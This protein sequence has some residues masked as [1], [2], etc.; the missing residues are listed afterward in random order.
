MIATG[1]QGVHNIDHKDSLYSITVSIGNP[2]QFF[3][4]SL[5]TG[6]ID[7]W[8]YSK[9]QKDEAKY[10][11]QNVSL[12]DPSKSYSFMKTK[13]LWNFVYDDFTYA[14][15]YIG[16]DSFQVGNIEI[17]GQKIEVITE[18]NTTSRGFDG[19]FGLG[20]PALPPHGNGATPQAKSPLENIFAQGHLKENVFAIQLNTHS[21]G[22]FTM[23]YYDKSQISKP[24]IKVPLN[25][26][27]ASKGMWMVD[28]KVVHI[29]GKPFQR[30][31]NTIMLLDSGCAHNYVSNDLVEAIYAQ[32]P[33]ARF[34]AQQGGWIYPYANKESKIVISFQIGSATFQVPHHALC[35]TGNT[36]HPTYCYGTFQDRGN[37]LWD[38]IGDPLYR[39]YLVAHWPETKEVGI[40]PRLGFIYDNEA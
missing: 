30:K 38:V 28:S 32:V 4:L 35:Y 15:G 22:L 17:I 21:D 27:W 33:G 18:T 11:A 8:I 13:D 7:W 24:M 23:G 1:V 25:K 10:A 9:G 37:L 2:P 20:L 31:P 5:D 29:N 40:A 12:F 39:Y 16:K 14:K 36:K 6:H 34:D 19:I 26:E 3:D